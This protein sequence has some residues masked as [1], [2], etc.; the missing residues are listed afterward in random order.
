MQ[1]QG[2]S[3]KQITEPFLLRLKAA[4]EADPALNVS[5]LATKAGL[6]NSAI[7]LMLA[8]NNSPRVDTMR[9]ICAA[10]GTTLEE[11]MSDAQTAEEREIVRLFAQLPDPLKQELLGYG[12]G[13][14]AAA[15]QSQPKGNA[16][17]E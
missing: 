16:D 8:R 5:N 9:K 15:G 12:R 6:G 10:L 7:R 3:D 13:L 1:N 2:M 11:F 17:D 4:I 14:A